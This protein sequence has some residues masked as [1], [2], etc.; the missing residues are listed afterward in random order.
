MCC[1]SCALKESTCPDKRYRSRCTC[2]FQGI[3][4][5]KFCIADLCESPHGQCSEC[6]D[7]HRVLCTFQW[8]SCDSEAL[9][10][11]TKRLPAP[12]HAQHRQHLHG[13]MQDCIVH[14]GRRDRRLCVSNRL[15]S[16]G[17]FQRQDH[18]NRSSRSDTRQEDSPARQETNAPQSTSDTAVYE[19]I[20]QSAHCR[21]QTL[22]KSCNFVLVI[23]WSSSF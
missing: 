5:D 9:P 4:R 8:R 22:C 13:N 16:Q 7:Q 12:C 1:V 18:C 21:Y 19:N 23:L 15:L 14:H 3:Q 11:D 6:S 10:C 17:L 20:F 2:I